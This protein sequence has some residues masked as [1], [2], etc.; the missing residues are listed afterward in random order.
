MCFGIPILVSLMAAPIYPLTRCEQEFFFFPHIYGHLCLHF[1]DDSF[2]KVRW[3]L[4]VVHLFYVYKYTA[5]IFRHTRRR[6][7]ITLQ[8]V[9]SQHVV[10]GNWTQDPFGRA[11]LKVVLISIF[12]MAMD[13]EWFKNIHWDNRQFS[14]IELKICSTRKKS[15]I[16]LED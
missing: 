13:S 7:Q 14:L 8:M 9:V 5:V 12:L 2:F 4:K 3:N 16:I 11:A 15:C 6:C 10:A 1:P